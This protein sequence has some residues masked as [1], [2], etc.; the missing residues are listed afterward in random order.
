MDLSPELLTPKT[1]LTALGG[2]LVITLSLVGVLY[3]K[4]T[5]TDKDQQKQLDEGDDEFTSNK[6]DVQKLQFEIAVLMLWKAEMIRELNEFEMKR[7]KD[8]EAVLLI[9]DHHL[10][11][12]GEKIE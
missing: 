1:L 12:H 4:L 6:L 5:E 11:N 10:R 8:H 9:K 2:V 3:H 7:M